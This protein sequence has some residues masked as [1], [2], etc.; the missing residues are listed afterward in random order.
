MAEHRR[1]KAERIVPGAPPRISVARRADGSLVITPEG[2]VE[3]VRPETV[4][5]EKPPHADD[6]RPAAARDIGGYYTY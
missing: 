3:C 4:A 1:D 6:P 5:A 2:D